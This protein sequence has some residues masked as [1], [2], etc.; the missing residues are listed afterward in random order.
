M[1]IGVCYNNSLIPHITKISETLGQV[2]DDVLKNVDGVKVEFF[3]S[4]NV[5]N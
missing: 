1:E 5:W 3:C 2:Q 4:I